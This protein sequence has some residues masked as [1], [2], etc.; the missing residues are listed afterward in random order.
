MVEHRGQVD[1]FL[2]YLRN[3]GMTLHAGSTA[4]RVGAV[5]LLNP[6]LDAYAEPASYVFTQDLTDTSLPSGIEKRLAPSAS[7]EQREEFLRTQP[8]L[9][10]DGMT[11]R[12]TPPA[13][14]GSKAFMFNKLELKRGARIVTNGVDVE[15]NALTL[16]SDGG[17]LLSFEPAQQPTNQA[18]VGNNGA[19]GLLAGT[20]VLQSFIKDNGILHVSLRGQNGQ[21]GGKGMQGPRGA[22]GPRGEN[23]ADHLFDCAHGG[24]NGGPGGRGGSGGQGGNGGAGGDGGRLVLRGPIINQ[25]MQIDFEAPGGKGGKGGEAGPGG[26]GGL[27]GQGGSGSTFCRGGIAGATGSSGEPGSPGK[28]GQNGHDGIITVE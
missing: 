5:L 12:F 16:I 18:S 20:L 11:L 4:L 14:G 17:H 15:I 10:L 6:L 23:A 19:S 3:V 27:G 25:R 21:I 22:P 9:T 8:S 26:D 13:Q 1:S 28:E 24:G 7:E 2:R